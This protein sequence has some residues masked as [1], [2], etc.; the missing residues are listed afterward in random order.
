M[1]TWRN[2]T[3]TF[4][5]TS[6]RSLMLPTRLIQNQIQSWKQNEEE[7]HLEILAKKLQPKKV[8]PGAN[9]SRLSFS[10]QPSPSF[11]FCPQKWFLRSQ[12]IAGFQARID[13]SIS[14]TNVWVS[15]VPPQFASAFMHFCCSCY[16]NNGIGN[17]QVSLIIQFLGKNPIYFD[18]HKQLHWIGI[19]LFSFHKCFMK[20]KGSLQY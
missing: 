2:M 14:S 6:V 15:N 8:T 1:I 20:L 13:L 19:K 5:M 11:Q 4:I 7:K 16:F 3:M 9:Q 10:H 12:D 18:G 17:R